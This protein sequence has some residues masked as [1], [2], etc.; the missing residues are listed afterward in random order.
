MFF[1]VSP[2]VWPVLSKRDKA[3][4]MRIYEQYPPLMVPG[5]LGAGPPKHQFLD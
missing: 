4:I 2:T 5:Q 1:S 3:T